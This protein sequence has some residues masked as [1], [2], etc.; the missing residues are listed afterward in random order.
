M[1]LQNIKNKPELLAPAGT[2]AVFETAI[3]AGADAVYIGAPMLNAR[4][5]AKHFSMAEIAAMIAYGHKHGVKVYVAM[6]SLL[7]EEEIAKTVETLHILEKLKVNGIIVQDLGVFYLIKKYFKKLPVHAS[8][9]LGAHNSLAVQQFARMGFNRVVLARETTLS[10]IK[11]FHQ[12]TKVELEVFV[13]GAACFSYSGLCLFSSYLGGKSSVRGRC[14][15]PCR[16]RYSWLGRGKG[17]GA[18]YFFSMNDLMAIDLIPQLQKAGVTSLKVEGRMRSAHYVGN[19]ISAYRMALDNSGEEQQVLKQAHELLAAAMGRKSTTGYFL[20]SRPQNIISPHHSGN[21]GVFLGKIVKRTKDGGQIILKKS[22]QVGDRLRLHLEKTGE[23]HS[24]TLK[25]LL[26]RGKIHRQG[27]K[28]ERVMLSLPA[29][30]EAGDSVYKVDISAKKLSPLKG[31]RISADRFKKKIINLV[32]DIGIKKIVDELKTELTCKQSKGHLSYRS[33]KRKDRYNSTLP[34][35]WRLTI[36]DVR[37]LQQHLPIMP[38]Q[39]TVNL[40]K[41]TFAQYRRMKKLTRPF[42]RHMIWALPA[43]IFEDDISFYE[44]AVCNLQKQGFFRWQIGHIGQLL[45][46]TNTHAHPSN[47]TKD[48]SRIKGKDIADDF[49]IN[50]YQNSDQ[51]GKIDKQCT[52]KANII[53]SD[54]TLNVFNSLSV[55]VLKA[56]GISEIQVAIDTDQKNL[57]KMSK[58]CPPITGMTVYGLPPL[59]TSRAALDFFQDGRSFVSPRGEKF[60]LKK[61]D[62][63]IQTFSNKPFSLL[64]Y[65]KEI[66]AMG[67]RYVVVDLSGI[68]LPKG[69]LNEICR[70]LAGGNVR[71]HHLNT[72]NYRGVLQ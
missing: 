1:I 71:G 32:Q 13:H 49:H 62:G 69:A 53:S 64:P 35:K 40:T 11:I 5:M 20:N 26:V 9:L 50:V 12:K 2:L 17:H 54:Y 38:D 15:Q 24:F 30:V 23:R 43:I 48:E 4:A 14:V 45:F 46:F 34:F 68:Y 41:K 72:F 37:L 51:I 44:E 60:I 47:T 67:I 58:H 57:L 22:L 56:Y 16:R 21:I 25:N 33:L 6:N 66:T 55:R 61:N 7:K 18:G 70:Q 28:R 36:D 31:Q 10:E 63:L 27:D 52:T 39:L 59:F 65:L 19:V 29:V 8:T 3:N 42:A